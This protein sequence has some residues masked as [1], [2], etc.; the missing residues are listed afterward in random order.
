ML[1]RCAAGEEP[2]V[3]ISAEADYWGGGL[4]QGVKTPLQSEDAWFGPHYLRGGV[5]GA[6]VRGQGSGVRE[7]I[8]KVEVLIK[9]EVKTCFVTYLSP[10]PHPCMKM[11]WQDFS[12]ISVGLSWWL[13]GSHHLFW[14]SLQHLRWN[15]SFQQEENLEQKQARVRESFDGRHN[16][17][18]CFL[19]VV[20]FKEGKLLYFFLF[21]LQYDWGAGS[22]YCLWSSEKTPPYKISS[23]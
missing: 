14:K 3:S 19:S 9:I 20:L 23:E 8:V 4:Q 21:C 13:V 6:K 22:Q 10:H 2:Q 7:C 18:L 17:L 12:F 16:I 5:W 11:T 1:D 15:L